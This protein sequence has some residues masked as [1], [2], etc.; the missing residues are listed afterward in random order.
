MTN[1]GRAA[2]GG[3]AG[4]VEVDD[5][6]VGDLLA[7]D[8]G[9]RDRALHGDDRGGRARREREGGDGRARDGDEQRPHVTVTCVFMWP[10]TS[11]ETQWRKV[12]R[13]G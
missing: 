6:L 4:V 11:L 8:A 9:E 2:P 12:K 10:S 1:S 7:L 13:T 5:A 3:V